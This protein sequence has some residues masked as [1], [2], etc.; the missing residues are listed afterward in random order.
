[1]SSLRMSASK[2]EA[3]RLAGLDGSQHDENWSKFEHNSAHIYKFQISLDPKL[4]W[5]AL[6][7]FE[8]EMAISKMN[9]QCKEDNLEFGDLNLAEWRVYNLHRSSMK[10]KENKRATVTDSSA[11]SKPASSMKYDPVRDAAASTQ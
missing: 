5:N 1:M 11:T 6:D 2:A 3:R 10:T 9:R 4:S 8:K 7:Q